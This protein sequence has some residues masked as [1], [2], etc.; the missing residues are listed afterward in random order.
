MDNLKR[1][2]ITTYNDS[3]ES[4]QYTQ[5][6]DV[7]VQ[8]EKLHKPSQ[9]H[10]ILPQYSSNKY[11]AYCQQHHEVI[12]PTVLTILSFWTRF[13]LISLSQIVVWDEAHFGKF[14]SHYIKHD[15]YFDVHPPLGKILVGLSGVLAGYNGSFGFDSGSTYPDGM[16]YGVMRVFNAMWGA[17]LVPLAYLTA[18]QLNFSIKASVL[19]ATMVLLDTALLCISRFI[20]LD[21]ML[22]FFTC[23]TL[24]SLSK[25]HNYRHESFSEEWYMWLFMT[26]LS[27][28]CVLSVKWVGLF[29]VALVGIYTVED[30]W[31]KLGDLQMPKVTYAKHWL[32][33][34]LC[35]IILPLTVYLFSFALHFALLYKSG[36]GDAQM[37]SLFQANLEGSSLGQ[38]PLE[39]AY[40]SKLTIKNFGYGGGLLHS[41]IQK[42]PEGSKQQQITCYHHKDDN[43]HWI[44]KTPRNGNPDD[45]EGGSDNDNNENTPIRYVTDGDVIR[46]MHAPTNVNLHSHPISAPVTTGQWEVSGYGND[47]VGDL[48]DNW[49]V[50]VVDDLA[51]GNDQHRIRSLTTRFRLRHVQQGCLLTANNVILPQ[52]GFKQV[53]VYCDKRNRLDDPHSWWNVEE[54]Y[55]DKLPPAPPNAYKSHFLQDFWHLNVAMWTSNNALVPDPDKIDILS[56]EPSE[57]P[58]ASVGLR[59]C[60]WDDNTIKFYLL[61]N[62]IVWWSSFVSILYFVGSALFYIVRMQRN[63]HDLTSGQWDQFLYVGKTLFL[64]WF[65]HYIPFFMMGRVTYLHHY[66]PA[67]YFSIFM[68]PF[69]LDH[70]TRTCSSRTQWIIFGTFFFL[71]I[72]VFIYFSP[73]AYGMKGPVNAYAGRKWLN[74]WN[75]VD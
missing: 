58:L 42:Y 10:T 21:S 29:A 72:T 65:L 22:L 71:V 48:Q 18:R 2:H 1:R 20:L 41:H 40:G 14:G 46:L 70:Y 4:T 73:L 60:G 28:G 57:W 12:I 34:I 52:W 74:S 55:N 61:G 67:L 3:F 11:I 44:I 9:P 59:M 54:H 6:V 63:I 37:S 17:L 27:L 64:G 8:Q 50:E 69:L 66:F 19:T 13:R 30:L 35:L 31:D 53:E 36:D 26:G 51:K 43:N 49:K 33:R 7:H 15:F 25:F 24:Y 5:P 32:A 68:G 62:P 75:L 39:L 38:N 23:T 45:Y 47:T 56:S 16:H